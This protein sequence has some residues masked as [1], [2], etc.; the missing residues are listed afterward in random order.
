MTEESRPFRVCSSCRQP[1]AF[2][3]TYWVC[4]V[5]TCNQSR[6]A[7]S[8]C[9][10]PCWEMHLPS[11]RH[12]DPWAEER[13]AP[14]REAWAQEQALA[15]ARTAVDPTP[16]APHRPLV[17]LSDTPRDVLV[18]VSKL[19]AYVKARAGMNTSDGVVDRL[20]EHLRDLCD[21][22]IRNAHA[23]GRVTVLER[24]VPRRR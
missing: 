20:S 5:S 10:V 14:T 24:D 19:K 15:V 8:F 18:V 3:A 21:E 1:I 6:T 12:R 22:A 13:R 16:A 11:M 23:D 17:L 9:S 4:S 2:G 7:L